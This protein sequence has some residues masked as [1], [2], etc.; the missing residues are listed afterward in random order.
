MPISPSNPPPPF[1]TGKL[2]PRRALSPH[3][4][5]GFAD[6]LG[7]P[8]Q[9]SA[10]LGTVIMSEAWN[11]VC[12]AFNFPVDSDPD[13]VV[14]WL[15]HH[16]SHPALSPSAW[17]PISAFRTELPPQEVFLVAE[18]VFREDGT[19]VPKGETDSYCF[20]TMEPKEGLVAFTEEGQKNIFPNYW[21]PI[22]EFPNARASSSSGTA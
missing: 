11:T 14:T 9:A 22:P 7:Q 2:P 17:L 16:I 8:N 21:L 20:G 10:R 3:E 19:S 13:D 18:V 12:Q 1:P 15:R 4:I 6:R 5:V